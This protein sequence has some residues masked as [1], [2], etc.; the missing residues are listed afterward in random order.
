MDFCSPHL[1]EVNEALQL[2]PSPLKFQFQIF[3]GRHRYYIGY[4]SPLRL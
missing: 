4:S 2:L 3:Y 1:G